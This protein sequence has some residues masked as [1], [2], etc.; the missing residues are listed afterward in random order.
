MKEFKLKWERLELWQ[1]IGL[2][3]TKVPKTLI[4]SGAISG[5]DIEVAAIFGLLCLLATSVAIG[6]SFLFAQKILSLGTVGAVI[7]GTLY[8]LIIFFLDRRLFRDTLKSAKFRLI[9]IGL[10]TFV[11]A[12]GTSVYI[13]EPEIKNIILKQ[14]ET[15]RLTQE[16]YFD[17][18][19]KEAQ[20]RVDDAKKTKLNTTTKTVQGSI[21]LATQTQINNILD[22]IND[23]PVAKGADSMK[24]VQR[25][26][27]LDQQ[28][29][30]I[31]GAN[32]R[33][34]DNIKQ[35]TTQ[36]EEIV[37]TA[38][39]DYEKEFAEVQRLKQELNKTP[40]QFTTGRMLATLINNVKDLGIAHLIAFLLIFIAEILPFFYRIIHNEYDITYALMIVA[41]TPINKLHLVLPELPKHIEELKEKERQNEIIK[42]QNAQSD[43][44]SDDD[45]NDEL[46]QI[47]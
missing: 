21:D 37:K 45:E 20:K 22:E 36:S 33:N 40:V 25:K 16:K 18:R 43:G 38:N 19:L 24:I 1:R 32:N 28:I 12:F 23:M 6:Q 31:R 7:F 26:K 29:K 46:S 4:E 13:T 15:N 5:N 17:A 34:N 30:N 41:K 11:F 8:G 35:A 2:K 10:S 44:N 42:N 27:S 39:T 47:I 3:I 14:E 9:L